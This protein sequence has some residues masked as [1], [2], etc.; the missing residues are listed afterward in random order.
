M[1]DRAALADRHKH[2]WH[3]YLDVD[4]G[5]R[6]ETVEITK[7]DEL[8]PVGQMLADANHVASIRAVNT[9]ETFFCGRV[10]PP[11]TLTAEKPE[12]KERPDGGFEVTF[13]FTY[14]PEGGGSS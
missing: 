9:G 10:Y 3:E 12:H 13:H 2:T 7:P 6:M 8:S 4:F 5:D 11:G 14:Q 1:L